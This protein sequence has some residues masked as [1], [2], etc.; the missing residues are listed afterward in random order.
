VTNPKVEISREAAARGTATACLAGDHAATGLRIAA[1][2][3]LS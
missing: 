3:I 2:F 1:L